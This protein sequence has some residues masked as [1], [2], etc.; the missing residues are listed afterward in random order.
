MFNKI[1][2]IKRLRTSV[3]HVE[4][5]IIMVTGQ[6]PMEIAAH[7]VNLH[8]LKVPWLPKDV[9]PEILLAW[10]NKFNIK[11]GWNVYLFQDAPE[12]KNAPD[13]RRK[14]HLLFEQHLPGVVLIDF[15]NPESYLRHIASETIHPEEKE[16]L[17]AN[18]RVA[19]ITDHNMP[20]M[21]GGH[22]AKI[23][24]RGWVSQKSLEKYV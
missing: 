8:R 11:S 18:D 13:R 20:K 7:G 23:I 10:I 4:I 9:S 17:Q 2:S 14:I 16:R 19:I 24:R 21:R 3:I 1:I 6:G 22:F 12:K 15:D 5:P